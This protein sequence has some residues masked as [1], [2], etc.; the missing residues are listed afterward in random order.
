MSHVRIYVGNENDPF[1]LE[2]VLKKGQKVLDSLD[3]ENGQRLILVHSSEDS[4]RDDYSSRTNGVQ[5]Y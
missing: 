4:F 3:V 1:D 2:K 5:I